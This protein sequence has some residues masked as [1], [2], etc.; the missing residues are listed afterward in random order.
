MICKFTILYRFSQKIFRP[1]PERMPYTGN[2]YPYAVAWGTYGMSALPVSCR[3]GECIRAFGECPNFH[4]L[5]NAVARG[6][7]GVSALPLSTY[8]IN[9]PVCRIAG[10][11]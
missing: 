9:K 10:R 7:H 8:R 1:L 4:I 11:R 3:M 2:L 6:T 5:L